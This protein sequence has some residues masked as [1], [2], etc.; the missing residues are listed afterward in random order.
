[1]PT[2][3]TY[4]TPHDWVTTDPLSAA[5]LQRLA[6]DVAYL[7]ARGDIQA[8]PATGV[9]AFTAA[10][11][12]IPGATLTFT[13]AAAG[14]YLLLATF[15]FQPNDATICVGLT[16]V[17][18][19]A[20]PMQALWTGATGARLT[21]SSINVAVLSATA[22]TIKLQA[23]KATAGGSVGNQHTRITAVRIR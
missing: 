5:R 14:I 13:P 8:Q 16:L 17:D 21:V 2:T 11:A 20:Q 23:S 12:D 4:T 19:V 1:M 9:L 6:D 7:E 22:H 10:A 15:D 18:G 3:S